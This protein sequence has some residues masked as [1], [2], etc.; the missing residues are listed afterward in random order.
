MRDRALALC[1]FLVLC[2]FLGI[3]LWKVPRID[4]LIVIGVTVA[5]AGYDLFFYHRR[6]DHG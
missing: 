5:F 2:G 6:D 4:L 3:L 1:G